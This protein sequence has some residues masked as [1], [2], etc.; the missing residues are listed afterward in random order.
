MK[1]ICAILLMII[2][3]T[4]PSISDEFKNVIFGIPFYTPETSLGLVLNDI[5]YFKKQEQKYYST[6]NTFLVYTAKQQIVVGLSPKIYF[7]GDNYLLESTLIY[8]NFKRKFYGIGNK[9]T[10]D[11]EEDYIKRSHGIDVG[12]SK[13]IFEN[14]RLGIQYDFS[15]TTMQDLD[16]NGQLR[17]YDNDGILSGIGTKITFDTRNNNIYPTTGCKLDLVYLLYNTDIGSKFDYSIIDIDFRNYIEVYKKRLLF[18]YQIYA[19]FINGQAPVQSLCSVGG[20]HFLRGFYSGRYIDNIVMA[21]Q[22]EV[23]FKITNVIYMA[24]FTGVGNVYNDLESIDIK[25]LKMASGVGIRI[26]MKNSPRMN[27]RIDYAVSNES[28]EIYFTMLEAF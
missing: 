17:F 7:D 3:F 18:S 10:E 25:K 9:T 13:K 27:F 16:E 19:G 23:K 8:S 1:K 24:L 4:R 20:P 22:P 2:L 14:I 15:D 6:V 21:I 5:V 11:T 26:K 12:F 28:K